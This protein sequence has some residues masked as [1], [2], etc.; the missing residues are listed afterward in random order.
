V[1]A[2]VSACTA[3]SVCSKTAIGHFQLPQRT[4]RRASAARSG[5]DRRVRRLL[6][7]SGILA[8]I[9]ELKTHTDR[10]RAIVHNASEWLAETPGNE[11]EAFV[12][13][14]SVHMLAPYLINLH[15]ADLLKRSTPPTSSTSAMT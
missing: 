4:P 13:M 5:R 6:Q 3:R 11:A 10:L 7:R 2:S 9:D 14:F 15:C 8:F 12:R 1:P